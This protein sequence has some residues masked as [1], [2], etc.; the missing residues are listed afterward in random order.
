MLSLRAS[1]LLLIAALLTPALAA[2][3]VITLSGTVRDFKGNNEAGGHV[4]F[5]NACCGMD[6]GV[7]TGTLGADGKPVYAGGS[8][9]THGAAAFNQWFRNV[10]GVN[11]SQSVSL[12]LS[13][14]LPGPGGIY[15][16]DNPNF[17]PIDGQLFGNTPGWGH[18]Y[19][20]TFELHTTFNYGGGENFT[21]V[22]DDDVFVYIN[23]K[24]V[25]NL[26]GVHGAAGAAVD[27][28]AMA[29]ALG[30]TT[31]HNYDLDL[32]FAER[33]TS[34]SS[35]RIQTTLALS[36]KPDPTVPEP[37]ILSLIGLGLLGVGLAR[38]KAIAK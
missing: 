9:S 34:A 1:S 4:D 2:A 25:I 18:N 33:H 38:R 29:G 31:G 23:D 21:F 30:I 15:T 10:P 26:G 37:G 13:N 11:L 24:L 36:P 20:F 27:L 5:E 32:F 12:N 17:F 8:W 22:G 28:D 19:G 14:G 7:V 35:F 16:Y 6:L 3:D